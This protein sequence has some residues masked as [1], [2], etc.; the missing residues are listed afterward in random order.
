[1]EFKL[2]TK[3]LQ[4]QLSDEEELIFKKWYDAD[5]KHRDYFY[6]IRNNNYK[7]IESIQ[8]KEAWKNI[9]KKLQLKKSRPYWQLSIAASI[10]LI[11]G[12]ICFFKIPN[13]FTAPEIQTLPNKTI[14]VVTEGKPVLTLENGNN[15]ILNEE[16]YNSQNVNSNGKELL[17]KRSTLA[18]SIDLKYNVLTVP[19]GSD[20]FV[21]LSDGTNVWLN[22]E[23]QIRYPVE[24]AGKSREVE[25]IYGEAYFEVT[26]S[27][28]HDGANFIVTSHDQSVEVIGT[29]FNLAS[30]QDSENTTT[31]LVEGKVML[32]YKSTLEAQEL[33]P[34]Q[35]ASFNN[36]T[37]QI[38]IK[39]VKTEDV[40]SWRNGIL[41][42]NNKTLEDIMAS[43]SRWYNLEVHYEDENLKQ[44]QFN[45][46]F[47][48]AQKIESILESIEKTKKAQ[49]VIK[50]QTIY[51]V[52]ATFNNSK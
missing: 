7:N 31:T 30:Y 44:Q 3:K 27:A 46:V 15:I 12:I 11:F 14:A 25:L 20:F 36:Q 48:K 39:R 40:T 41:R 8:T 2:I 43:L 26:S 49:F 28:L 10:I 37:N 35:Q 18:D 4:N 34:S 9:F 23:S 45:G 29:V 17:Y 47:R 50:D 32:N 22:S 42:F 33:K 19:R 21:R 16:N 24:F 5:V 6:K 13:D 1:M 52:K 38:E 51:I